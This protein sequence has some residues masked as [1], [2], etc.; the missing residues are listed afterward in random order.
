MM[1]KNLM[2][3][4]NLDLNFKLKLP[5][6][7]KREK[8]LKLNSPST[9]CIMLIQFYFAF[10]YIFFLDTYNDVLKYAR[11]LQVEHLENDK[12]AMDGIIC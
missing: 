9:V 10:L 1:K 2:E 4:K 3:K 5:V 6:N 11:T 8:N 7:T 12:R